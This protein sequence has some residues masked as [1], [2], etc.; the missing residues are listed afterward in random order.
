MT[1]EQLEDFKR[2]L[3][4]KLSERDAPLVEVL[5]SMKSLVEQWELARQE[6]LQAKQED[7]RDEQMAAVARAVTR[8][9]DGLTSAARSQRASYD[10]I[11]GA[12]IEMLGVGGESLAILQDNLEMLLTKMSVEEIAAK[13]PHH[14]ICAVR[15]WQYEHG[16]A[17]RSSEN[18]PAKLPP[19]PD[20]QQTLVAVAA[21]ASSV[22]VDEDDSIVFHTQKDGKAHI[23]ANIKVKT[24]FGWIVGLVMAGLYLYEKIQG[25]HAH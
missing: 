5:R 24:V 4:T 8:L 19:T 9:A 18:T 12:L 10:E 22:T 11:K 2:F 6:D 15:T 20:Q 14:T 1:Q 16:D 17:N 25:M 21:P 3:E 13:I 23:R 7:Q